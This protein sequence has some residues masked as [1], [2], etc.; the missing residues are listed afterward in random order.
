[1]RSYSPS[2]LVQGGQGRTEGRLEAS[3]KEKGVGQPCGNGK[4]RDRTVVS[5]YVV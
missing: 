5:F 4:M 2:D 3:G 1:M